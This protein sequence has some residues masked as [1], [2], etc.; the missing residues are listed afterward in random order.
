[1][2]RAGRLKLTEVEIR[3]RTLAAQHVFAVR[4]ARAV[5]LWLALTAFGLAVGVAG[6]VYFESL[7][8]SDAFVNAAMILS[9][10]GPVLTVFKTESGKWF[11]GCYA[12]F[13][14]LVIVIATGFV[15]AP[16]F[17]HV[18]HKFHVETSKDS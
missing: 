4:M 8:L 1:M 5:G 17:H 16:I 6:Y 2:P 3:A 15:L 9:G 13:S 18:L 12:I 11:A 7:S 14:G 10:M